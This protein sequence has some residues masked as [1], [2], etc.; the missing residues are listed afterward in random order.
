LSTRPRSTRLLTLAVSPLGEATAV[1]AAIFALYL[2]VNIAGLLLVGAYQD[3]GVYSILGRA[4]AQGHGYRSMHLAGAPV[5]VKYPPGFPLLLSAIWRLVPSV[6]GLQRVVAILHP[7]M[8][9][10]AAGLMWWT[11]RVRFGASRSAL[12]LFVLIPLLLDAAITYYTIPLSEP[13]FILAWAAAV[14][15]FD[16]CG[17]D[18]GKGHRIASFAA[19][20][21]L[22]ATAALF[23]TTGLVFV[24][25]MI[26]ALALRRSTILQWATALFT[27]LAPLVSWTIY[28]QRLIAIGP[29]S[30]LPDE[31]SYAAWTTY[32][33]ASPVATAR[34]VLRQN[35]L[36][37]LHVFGGYF[38][39]VP[40]LGA[41][42]AALIIGGT[43]IGTCAA[44]RRTPFLALSA[45]GAAMTVMFWPIAQDRL[46][47]P[48]LPFLGLAAV[49]GLAPMTAM[50]S[51]RAQFGA[52]AVTALVVVSILL[53]QLD[54]HVEAVRSLVER[55]EPRFFSP[56]YPLLANSRFIGRTSRWIRDN[57]KP[58]DR[59]MIADAA[60]VYLY[61]DRITVPAHP[62]E[63]AFSKSVFLE[64]GRYLSDHLL[65][66][67]I[68]FV[69]SSE[70]PTAF[71]ESGRALPGLLRDI[72]A[73]NARCPGILVYSASVP[74][75]LYR[76]DLT[77]PCLRQF[78]ASA[79]TIRS[80]Q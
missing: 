80:P 74:S 10:V 58:A 33:G 77:A 79:G 50:M 54:I 52:R 47:L 37:Y 25:A 40:T 76:V 66:D 26:I 12:A 7:A 53:R 38:N 39:A 71:A 43:V 32:G 67:S 24:P 57:T 45:L 62:T 27:C 19:L 8:I 61:S 75:D 31:S 36:D 69:F 21:G 60:G 56:A 14:V 73:V 72:D 44:V 46:L 23:R 64:P 65:A 63:A 41:W 29:V 3:D 35:T 42:L 18:A 6:S 4:I 51:V 30:N 49:S 17:S 11:G 78:R 55:R 9:A 5:Q 22:V 34:L 70:D 20:G 16:R 68:A 48:I 15:V 1:A 59:I 2:S 13:G 28:H